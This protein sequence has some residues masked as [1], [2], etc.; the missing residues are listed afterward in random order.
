MLLDFPEM[1]AAGNVWV[2]EI[3]GRLV[4]VLVQ[5]ETQAGFYIDKIGR[6]HV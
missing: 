6:A 1:I 3:A 4:G 2:A 5:Y